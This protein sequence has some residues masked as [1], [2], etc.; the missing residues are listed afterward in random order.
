MGS[1][2]YK[3]PSE[4]GSRPAAGSLS[5]NLGGSWLP[6]MVRAH[7]SAQATDTVSVSPDA[8]WVCSF[9]VLRVLPIFSFSVGSGKE[10][11]QLCQSGGRCLH[12]LP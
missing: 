12:Q 9:G 1:S 11:P 8:T 5:G 3:P 2:S 4:G 7:W 10:P 6:G